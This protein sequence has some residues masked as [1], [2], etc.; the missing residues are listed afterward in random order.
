MPSDQ[1]FTLPANPADYA[2]KGHGKNLVLIYLRKSYIKGKV[3]LI[4]IQYQLD[5][6]L[7][8]AWRDQ[9][10]FKVYVDAKRSNSARSEQ[11]RA[12]WRD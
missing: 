12:D 8:V 11:G 4:S 7:P 2:P 1:P 5:V 3:D 10:R 6:T 9:L